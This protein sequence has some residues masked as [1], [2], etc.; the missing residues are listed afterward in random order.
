MENYSVHNKTKQKVAARQKLQDSITLAYSVALGE[1]PFSVLS[2]SRSCRKDSASSDC[3][4]KPNLDLEFKAKLKALEAAQ[5]ENCPQI[6]LDKAGRDSLLRALDRHQST[7][8]SITTSSAGALDLGLL[9]ELVDFFHQLMRCPP[10]VFQSSTLAG[11]MCKV[12]EIF[13]RSKCHNLRKL[14]KIAGSIVHKWDPGVTLVPSI[15]DICLRRRVCQKIAVSL[16][17]TGYVKDKAQEVA[18]VLEGK[19]RKK[20]PSMGRTYRHYFNCMYKDINSST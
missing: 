7:V 5:F 1:V 3:A 10:E 4:D 6:P 12:Q 14:A 9:N 17:S 20:D 8:S 19:L 16:Q 15:P 13:C 11:L 18:L 2:R